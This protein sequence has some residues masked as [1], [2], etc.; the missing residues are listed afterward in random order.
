MELAMDED[1]TPDTLH[2]TAKYFMDS[3]RVASHREA[4]DMLRAFGLYIQA[5]PEVAVSRDHQVALLT[6]VN[7]A[8]RTF[9]GGVRV[10]GAPD[11]PLLASVTDAT[12]VREAVNC[13]GGTTV[14]KRSRDWPIAVI[15]TV[16][17]GVVLAPSWRVT[18]DGWRGGVV[19]VRDGQRLAERP[20]GG[21]AA[22]FAAAVCAAEVF[23]FHA[24]DHPL[25]GRRTA[26][27]S[28]WL[29]GVDWLSDDATEAQI[30]FLPSRLWLIGLGNLGQ[31][32]LWV[33]TC[34]VYGSPNDLE[35]LLQDDDRVARSN[36]S[37]SVLTVD[38]MIGRMKT[39]T[40]AEW[41]EKRGFRTI[42]DERRF[43]EWSRRAPHEP[44][45]ALC[46]VDN[47]LARASLER[48]GFELVVETGLGAGPQSFRNFSLH[49]FPSSLSAAEIWSRDLDPSGLN[50]ATMP[51]YKPSNHLGLDE[52]GLAQLASR[53]VGVPFVGLAAAALAIAELLRR[54]HGGVALELLS[55]SV[56]ALE[57]VDVSSTSCGIYEFGHVAARDVR[58]A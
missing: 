24:G 5:G 30:A 25:A 44:A 53:T 14:E 11:A 48:T 32:Y 40:M 39:R 58:E 36:D 31:A 16:D 8:R 3:G 6:L 43:G 51:A 18:W 54:L 28:L 42:L 17:V 57:D 35:L 2:R 45:V 23:M 15:G 19:P 1:I 22:A 21:L 12:T 29:P 50:V 27:M 13:L 33:L 55:G 38:S 47:A 4:M 52:C 46:G 10:I 9:L 7:A 26:G 56:A 20:S 49:T 37:T 34:L 41:L